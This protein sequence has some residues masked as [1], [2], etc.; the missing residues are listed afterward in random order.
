MPKTLKN[1]KG[2]IFIDLKDGMSATETFYDFIKNSKISYFSKGGNGLII[3][4]VVNDGYKSSYK[5]TNQEAYNKP[6]T[7]LIL[8]LALMNNNEISNFIREVN[9]QTEIFKGSMSYLQPLC[10]AII[11]SDILDNNESK[12]EFIKILLTKNRS[13][14][15]YKLP[16][17]YQEYRY[18]FNLDSRI[19]NENYINLG[20][21]G[22]ECATGYTPLWDIVHDKLIDNNHKVLYINYS[23][24]VILKLALDFGYTHGDFHSSNIMIHK[25][26]EY[27][28]GLDGRAMLI[29][30]GYSNKIPEEKIKEIKDLVDN[31]RYIEALQRLCYIERADQELPE[32]YEWRK[33]YGWICNDWDFLLS[34]VE[35][36]N[37]GKEKMMN[38]ETLLKYEKIKKTYEL[39][40]LQKRHYNY[41]VN[42][43]K[44]SGK[45]LHSSDDTLKNLFTK[46]E[47]KESQIMFESVEL[48]K[49]EPEKYPELPLTKK[50]KERVYQGIT[51]SPKKRGGRKMKK[52]Q[53]NKTTRKMR[54][55]CKFRQ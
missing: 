14:T 47:E 10:P 4:A 42:Q 38:Y 29:D 53:K 46:R 7:E 37:N 18:D 44:P 26:I 40:D 9:V 54:K 30:F 27:F 11:Y 8:K 15:Q 41:V 33:L 12:K 36:E 35:N 23:L 52:T 17:Y 49:K 16:F 45:I 6:V 43:F 20:I 34:D 51:F 50:E 13:L 31:N 2:G 21:I 25:N 32:T 28:N 24:Y 3:K 5:Y 1:K 19:I 22:M 48:N 55:T 39:N